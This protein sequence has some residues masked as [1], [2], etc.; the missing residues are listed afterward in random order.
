MLDFL[1]V[2][3]IATDSVFVCILIV[4]ILFFDKKYDL[5]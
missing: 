5:I 1:F 2:L 3:L 4:S